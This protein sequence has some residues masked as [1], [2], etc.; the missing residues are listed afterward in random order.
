MKFLPPLGS[1]DTIQFEDTTWDGEQAS[2]GV[3]C[4]HYLSLIVFYET[5]EDVKV[6]P[7]TDQE[8][9]YPH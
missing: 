7:S 3:L 8:T 4:I 6:C 9:S 2:R 1:L 5:L